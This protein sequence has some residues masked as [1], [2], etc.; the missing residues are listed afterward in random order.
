MISPYVY[1][2]LRRS[3]ET[4][5]ALQIICEQIGVTEDEV[6]GRSRKRD[7]VIARHIFCFV[8]HLYYNKRLTQIGRILNRDHSSVIHAIK[9]VCNEQ[10]TNT[11]FKK[12]FE[13]IC[14]AINYEF[15]TTL[16]QTIHE[17]NNRATTAHQQR[18]F[19]AISNN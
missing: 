4:K 15:G 18:I 7:Y 1:V 9:A 14:Y 13:R 5:D 6:K 2:G 19:Q 16:K 17:Y 11:D 10:E 8:S 12:T 3:K